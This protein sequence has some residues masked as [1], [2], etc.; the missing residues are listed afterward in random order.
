MGASG[1]AALPR[2]LSAEPMARQTRHE[3]AL[4]SLK[5]VC[6]AHLSV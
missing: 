2:L 5:L 1:G 6:A 3:H 4:T